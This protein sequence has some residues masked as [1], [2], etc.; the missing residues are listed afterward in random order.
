MN[1][2]EFFMSNF[3]L[4]LLIFIIGKILYK[5]FKKKLKISKY[6]KVYDYNFYF[7]LLL[8]EGNY[9]CFSYYFAADLRTFFYLTS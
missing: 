1:T 5:I 3:F 9:E 4:V 7:F 6:I 2:V 8:L